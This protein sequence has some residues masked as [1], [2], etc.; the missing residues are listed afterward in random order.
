MSRILFKI[1]IFLLILWALYYFRNIWL[2]LVL[3]FIIS[4]ALYP[5][6][7]FFESKKIPRFIST[8][9]IFGLFVG[10]VSALL[11]TLFPAAL[12]QIK[13]FIFNFQSIST[14]F[15][16][17][18]FPKEIA[19]SL[20]KGINYGF[21]HFLRDSQKILGLFSSVFGG[22]IKFFVIIILSFYFTL[23]KN[24]LE[25][26]VKPFLE[27][28]NYRKFSLLYEKIKKRIS[29]WFVTE[30]FLCLIIGFV[31]FLALFLF[32][33]KYAAIL[34]IL[35]GIF[36][37]IPIFGPLISGTIA[38]LIAS[39]ASLVKGIWVVI[40]FIIIQRLENDLLIPL[41]MKKTL[42]ID[43]ALVLITLLIGSRLAGFIGF[44]LAVPTIVIL[45]EIYEAYKISNKNR[46][47]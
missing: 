3:S 6:V 19:P 38:F 43:P 22:L 44:I 13:D 32:K 17:N 24:I 28:K 35:A 26:A 45:Q 40:V 41:M 30:M 34:G 14:N 21:H 31:S 20:A 5:L 9:V 27:E 12:Y 4:L 42:K 1:S 29:R 33:V 11:I 25:K 46:S 2:I 10:L 16:N 23:E 7:D 39:S 15:V 8:L 36:E 47:E 37:I 18:Y